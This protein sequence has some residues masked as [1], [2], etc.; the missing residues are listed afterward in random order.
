MEAF[1]ARQAIFDRE[2]RVYGYELLFRSSPENAF[3]GSDATAS[4]TQLLSN[5]LMAIGL[6]QLVGHKKAFVNFGRDLLLSG[7]A[8]VLPKERTVIE[9][10]ETVVPEPDVLTACESLRSQGYL[11]ALDDFVVRSGQEA[12]LPHADIV[13]VEFGSLP[14]AQHVDLV[15]E[16]HRRNLKMLAEKVESPEEFRAARAAGYD[17]FQGYFFARPTVVRSKQIPANKLNSLRL[18]REVVL[19]ELDLTR[20]SDLISSD[21]GLTYK[22]L[23][24]VNSARFAT[25][26]RIESVRQALMFPGE[27][28]IR[29]WVAMAALPKASADKPT[30]LLTA[31]L[32]RAWMSE[33]LARLA[34]YPRPEHAF[35]TGLLSFLDALLDQPLDVAVAEIGLAPPI[36]SALLGTAPEGDPLTEIYALVRSYEAGEW[37]SLIGPA[38]RLDIDA[39]LIRNTYCE[40]VAWAERSV[41]ESAQ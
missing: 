17:Y 4:T 20:L 31:S 8:S 7:F 41:M 18:M 32:V 10:L 38:K 9:I 25:S 34:N 33:S 37:D 27:A 30:E 5:S 2:R 24:Y 22:L 6:D 19:P 12:F 16:Y 26:T 35:L 14:V 3:D 36:L 39:E 28:Q 40:A 21:V 23:R 13:K 1:V 29:K 15:R 11:L